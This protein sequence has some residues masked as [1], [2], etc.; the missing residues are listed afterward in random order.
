MPDTVTAATTVQSP[1]LSSKLPAVAILAGLIGIAIF[2]FRDILGNMLMEWETEEYS[3]CYLIPPV[4]LFLMATRARELAAAQWSGSFQ[5]LLLMTAGYVLLALSQLSSIFALGHAGFILVLWGCFL[6]VL[7]WPAVRTIWPA[8]LYLVFMVPLPDFLENRLSGSLQLWS[9]EL[10][11]AVI[12]LANVPVYLQGNVIDLGSYQLQVAEACSGMRYLFPL[13]SFGFLCAAIFVAPVWQRAV[14]FLSAAP[15]TVLMNSFRVGVIGILVDRF[16]IEQAE[17]FLHDFEGWVVFMACVGV[18]FFEMLVLA[19]LSGRGLLRSLSMDTPPV[20]EMLRSLARPMTPTAGWAALGAIVA[21]T[22]LVAMLDNRS[23]IIPKR[24]ALATF[25]LVVGEWRGSEEAV[26]RIVLGGLKATDTLMAVYGRDTDPMP[27][28]LWVAY[29][30]S[31]RSGQAVHSPAACLPGG[32]W[33][34]ESL[35]V[36]EIPNAR[37]DG[38]SLPVNRSVISQGEIRQLVY[39]WFP[40]RGRQLTSEYLVKWYIFWDGMTTR[41][42]DGALVRLTTAVADPGGIE[43]ADQRLQEFV[44]TIDPRLGYFLP[45]ASAAGEEAVARAQ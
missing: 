5:G 45:P 1:R 6:A 4:A 12:R 22:G 18:L 35:A 39:Y 43:A 42:S 31:Q 16:G 2:A 9:S 24:A 21:F 3:H 33:L 10:G 32:G 13:M 15:I 41:R 26:D 28:G 19:R 20:G 44:R 40:Q 29:Y 23:E 7:G 38:S 37:A 17:G 34:M 27:V 25:P 14:V 8:L 36:L 30:D 11:V